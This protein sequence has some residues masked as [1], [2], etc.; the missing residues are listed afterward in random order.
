MLLGPVGILRNMSQTVMRHPFCNFLTYL[1]VVNLTEIKWSGS[2]V[3]PKDRNKMAGV[4][5]TGREG[6]LLDLHVRVSQ[7]QFLWIC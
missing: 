5:E 6:N 3:F 7:Q 1:H 4:C 2:R